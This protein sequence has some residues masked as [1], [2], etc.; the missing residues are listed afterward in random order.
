MIRT[1]SVVAAG[2]GLALSASAALADCGHNVNAQSKP[3]Q[4]ITTAEAPP[5]AQAPATVKN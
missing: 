2:L 5:P 1:A 4:P 3:A